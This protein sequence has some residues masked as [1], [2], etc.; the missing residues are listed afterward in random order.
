MATKKQVEGK[1]RELI[2]RLDQAG[3]EQQRQLAGALPDPRVI[4]IDV[5]DI[6]ALYWTELADGKLRALHAGARD[7]WDMRV[8]A[9][10]DLLIAMIDGNRNLLTSYLAGHVKVQASLSDIMALRKL[11]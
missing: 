7:E 9:D 2:R 4:Q 11:V 5:P 8:T 6:E 1:L 10:S 3:D